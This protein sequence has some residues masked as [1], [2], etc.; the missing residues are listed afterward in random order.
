MV[1]GYSDPFSSPSSHCITA[2]F[3]LMATMGAMFTPQRHI[4]LL[5]PHQST[6]RMT[7]RARGT[8]EGLRAVLLLVSL[9]DL[10]LDDKCLV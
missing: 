7:D 4:D 1:M 2:A 6:N 9:L 5:T 10:Q 8:A 3:V